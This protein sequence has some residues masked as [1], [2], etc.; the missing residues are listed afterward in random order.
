[1]TMRSESRGSGAEEKEDA[2]AADEVVASRR[3]KGRVM[4]RACLLSEEK[5][6]PFGTE[7]EFQTCG[8]EEFCFGLDC[9]YRGAWVGETSGMLQ[10]GL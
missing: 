5:L 10:L 6:S 1:M 8:D 2:S 4:G 7:E 9:S 3:R